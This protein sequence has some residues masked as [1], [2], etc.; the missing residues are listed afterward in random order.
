M[1]HITNRGIEKTTE[2]MQKEFMQKNIE[3]IVKIILFSEV[4][5]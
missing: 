5:L 3:L 1:I 2:Q 4:I